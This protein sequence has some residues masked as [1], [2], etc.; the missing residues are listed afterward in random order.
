[1]SALG[2]KD[3]DPHKAAETSVGRAT[4]RPLGVVK[5]K[6]LARGLVWWPGIDK[7]NRKGGTVMQG[8]PGVQARPQVNAT[9]SLGATGWA[10]EKNP[11]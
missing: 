3:G 6:S 11:P 7:P 2:W 5:M 8:L 4:R 9:T 10:M 1:M